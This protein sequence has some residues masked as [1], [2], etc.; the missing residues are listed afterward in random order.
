[1]AQGP[2]I[3]GMREFDTPR[4]GGLGW[5]WWVVIGVALVLAL[6]V[7]AGFVGGVGPLR[8]LG[9]ATSELQPVQYRPTTVDTVIQVGVSMPP[10]GLCRD[11]DVIVVAF[12]RGSRVEVE[13]SVTRPRRE[14]CQVEAVAGDIVWADVELQEPLGDRTVIRLPDRSPLSRESGTG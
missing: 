14:R 8:M 9:L 6:V 11:D 5:V 4:R 3:P 2:L 7:G 10:S 13:A 12:E 1:M